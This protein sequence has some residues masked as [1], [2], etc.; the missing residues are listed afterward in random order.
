M[1]IIYYIAIFYVSFSII[2]CNDTFEEI[3]TYKENGHTISSY[4]SDDTDVT[5]DEAL[6]VADRFLNKTIS[7]SSGNGKSQS[8]DIESVKEEGKPIFYVVNYPEGGFAI[9]SATKDYYPILAYSDEN[10]FD[11]S[12]LNIG[13][14]D[15]MEESKKAISNVHL[16]SDS[17]KSRNRALWTHVEVHDINSSKPLSRSSNPTSGPMACWNRCDQLQMRYGG[18]GWNFA[19]LSAVRDIFEN[20]GLTTQYNNLLYS[21]D[22]NHSLPSS[23]VIGWKDNVIRHEKGPFLNTQWHQ[24]APFN[25]QCDGELAGCAAIALAQVMKYYEF[26]QT[27]SYNG[28][29]FDWSNIPNF[30]SSESDQA[31]LVKLVRDCIGSQNFFGNIFTTPGGLRDGIR[32]LGYSVSVEDHDY[33]TV[34]RYMENERPVIMLGNDDNLE[35]LFGDMEYIGSSHYWVADGI[36]RRIENQLT[37]FTEWQ[38]YDN[39]TFIEGYQNVQNPAVEGGITYLYFHMNW[40][41]GGTNNGWFSFNSAR[42]DDDHDYEHS[43]KNFYLSPN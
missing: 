28:Y 15:W 41:H 42:E 34:E 6:A 38:P 20:V 18:D 11:I 30:Y 1:K 27:F 7:R 33:S 13:L 9:V 43:R 12:D 8:A 17:V 4:I 5:K 22:Y 24:R 37:Y 14:S 2:S 40:G 23:S 16:E 31:Y 35:V 26:P 25:N 21:A 3:D 39:G 10:K 19:P 29:Y 36:N 32:L